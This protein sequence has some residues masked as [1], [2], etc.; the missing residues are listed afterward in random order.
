MT[1][2]YHWTVAVCATLFSVAAFATDYTWTGG[3]GDDNG[4]RTGANW[5]RTDNKYP[6]G[7]GDIALFTADAPVEV[8]LGADEKIKTMTIAA[9]ATVVLKTDTA[10]TLR[11]IECTDNITL[12]NEGISL[13]AD[14]VHLYRNREYTL[15]A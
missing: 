7:T 3:G 4:W 10:G 12:A 11:K 9:G 1:R 2:G 15:G 14:G 6:S 13:T 5:G 8:V